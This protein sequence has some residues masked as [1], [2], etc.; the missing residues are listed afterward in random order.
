MLAEACGGAALFGG[1]PAEQLAGR[2]FDA[3]LDIEARPETALLVVMGMDIEALQGAVLRYY[4]V[5]MEWDGALQLNFIQNIPLDVWTILGR[6][7]S[8]PVEALEAAQFMGEL[9]AE[10]FQQ[11]ASTNVIPWERTGALGVWS[12]KGIEI[13]ARGG[14]GFVK[15]VPIEYAGMLQLVLIKP[16]SVEVKARLQK[17]QSI[18]IEA[19]GLSMAIVDSFNVLSK[20]VEPFLD[21]FDVT[22]SRLV[23]NLPDQFNVVVLHGNQFPD[24]FRV[25][26]EEIVNLF[27]SDIQQPVGKAEVL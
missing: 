19:S 22:A 2:G 18:A 17:D 27:D 9:P 23:D 7:V 12:I 1:I 4:P 10:T 26:A 25:L 21:E 16:L 14:I 3:L 20:L 13:D 6:E 15:G 11:L 5:P 8:I 24:T